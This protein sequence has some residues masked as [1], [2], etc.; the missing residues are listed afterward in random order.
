MII[1]VKCFTCGKVLGDKYRYYGQEVRK[2]KSEKDMNI[3]SV[4][5]LNSDDIKKT[6]EGEVMDKL[7]LTKYCC[8]RHILTH[9][10]LE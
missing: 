4:I 1:P 9:V 5:Y 6:P 8:R 10:D 3:D 7:K 2:I